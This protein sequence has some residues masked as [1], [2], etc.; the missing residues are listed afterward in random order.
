MEASTALKQKDSVKER[1]KNVKLNSNHMITVS[2]KKGVAPK[3]FYDFAETIKMPE[4]DL[5]EL[6]NLSSRTVLNYFNQNKPLQPVYGEH[7]LKLIAL[8]KKGEQLFRT[9]NEFNYWLQKPMGNAREIPFE[10]LN[11]PGGV[12][13]VSEELERLAQGYPA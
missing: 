3:L 11:T 4:K 5:A 12:D 1:F 10:W 9:V 13:L 6:I 2:A 7:L 8:Y